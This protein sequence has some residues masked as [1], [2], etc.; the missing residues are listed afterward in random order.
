M[1]KL[2]INSL[3]ELPKK[4]QTQSFLK[5]KQFFYILLGVLVFLGIDLLYYIFHLKPDQALLPIKYNY[6]FGIVK[7]G[8]FKESFFLPLLLFVVT[9]GNLVLAEFF[10]RRDKFLTYALLIINFFF[11]ILIF[12]EMVALNG[13]GS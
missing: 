6:L 1:K 10:Y 13:R 5:E 11:T 9:V 12:L 3:K 8:S 7:T 2:D 4:I